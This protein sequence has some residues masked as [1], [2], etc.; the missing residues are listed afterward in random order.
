LPGRSVGVP[1]RKPRADHCPP[2]T[3]SHS[4]GACLRRRSHPRIR[5]REWYVPRSVNRP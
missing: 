3:P 4:L 5:F 1:F 2:F